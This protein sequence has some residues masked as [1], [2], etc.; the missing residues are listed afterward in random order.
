MTAPPECAADLTFMQR[1]MVQHAHPLKLGCDSAG[2]VACFSLTWRRQL[3]A[4]LV[5]LFGSSVLGSVLT[6]RADPSRLVVTRLGRWMLGQA[7]PV[8]LVLRTA[9]FT[10]AL[11][12]TWRHSTGLIVGGAAA[13]I[14]ARALSGSRL[15]RRATGQAKKDSNEV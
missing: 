12:G 8:N 7:E 13:I 5:V 6:R 11:V 9:G 10:L 14:A 4:A 1:V 15:K 2:V 3:P